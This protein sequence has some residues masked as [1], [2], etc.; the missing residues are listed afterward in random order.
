MVISSHLAVVGYVK[1]SNF[2]FNVL[3][4]LSRLIGIHFD[5]YKNKIQIFNF[6]FSIGYIEG[7][8]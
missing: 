4:V 5:H 3:S 8:R 7:L 1:H 6:A 2:P